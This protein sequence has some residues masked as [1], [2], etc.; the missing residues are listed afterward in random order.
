MPGMTVS[1]EVAE[2]VLEFDR[3]VALGDI[4]GHDLK[5]ANA[6][7]VLSWGVFQNMALSQW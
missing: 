1:D 3:S 2:L 6:I 7:G 5:V 4:M